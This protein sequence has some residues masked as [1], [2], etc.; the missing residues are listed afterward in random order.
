[1][2]TLL[3]A[4]AQA[5]CRLGMRSVIGQGGKF[6]ISEARCFDDVL[7]TE[8][9]VVLVDFLLP[10]MEG[11]FGVRELRSVMP[12]TKLVV[13]LDKQDDREAIFSL[14]MVGIHGLVD[15]NESPE[16]IA[17][18]VHRVINGEIV[19]PYAVCEGLPHAPVRTHGCLTRRQNAV[20]E[21]MREG[22]SNKQ[23]ARELGICEGTVKVHVAALFRHL[24]VHNRV[25]ALNAVKVPQTVA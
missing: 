15:K 17:T 6:E 3:I 10:G 12:K 8:P 19:V 9:D 22:K 1:M 20:L 24:G 16:R 25:S 21:L 5:L 2:L 23:I 4:D 11:M 18:V 13:M 7:R 14:I